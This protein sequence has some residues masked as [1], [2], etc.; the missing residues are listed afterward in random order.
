ML[1]CGRYEDTEVLKNPADPNRRCIIINLEHFPFI[2]LPI[3]HV[4]DHPCN[5]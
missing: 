4:N 5:R 3:G 2:E 1:Y